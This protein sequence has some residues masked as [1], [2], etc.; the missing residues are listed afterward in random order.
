MDQRTNR[1]KF[2]TGMV[3]SDK[4]NKTRVVQV[5][6]TSM[7]EKYDKTIRRAVKYKAHDE[8]N[9]SRTGDTVRI[10]ETRPISKEKRWM[11]QEIVKK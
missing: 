1:R 9:E 8:K 11:I 10:M 3:I 5:R 4:M 2:L 6:F 7:H